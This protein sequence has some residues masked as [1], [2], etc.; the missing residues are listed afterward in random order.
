MGGIRTIQ[1]S[2][3]MFFF[4]VQATA[5]FWYGIITGGMTVEK[6]VSTNRKAYYQYEI[7]E[8]IEAGLALTGTEIKSIRAGKASLAGAFGRP[9]HGEL[10]LLNATIAPYDSG[11]RYNHQPDRPRKLLLHRGQIN[12]LTGLV[13]QKG[14]TLVPLRLYLKDGLA[15]VEMGLARG[16]KIHDKRRSIAER[17]VKR[18]IERTLKTRRLK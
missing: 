5:P 14:F 18:D 9:D 4:C 2:Q 12:R 1:P 13:T 17:E 16:K 15:K 7:D 3:S 6:T 8:A 11:N 10:W